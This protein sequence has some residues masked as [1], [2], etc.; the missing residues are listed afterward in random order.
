MSD[1]LAKMLKGGSTADHDGQTQTQK[2]LQ[3]QLKKQAKKIKKMKTTET[4]EVKA[5]KTQNSASQRRQHHGF[6]I[7]PIGS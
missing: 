7:E 3:K 5:G 6:R 1:Y 2:K 4:Q